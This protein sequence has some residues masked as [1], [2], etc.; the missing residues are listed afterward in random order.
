M[1]KVNI[2]I[3]IPVD[4]NIEDILVT[5]YYDAASYFI[6][7]KKIAPRT[8]KFREIIDRNYINTGE[9]YT[10]I[11]HIKPVL[12]ESPKFYFNYEYDDNVVV[13]EMIQDEC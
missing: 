1:K 11:T 4:C 5:N 10:D 9:Y 7:Y 13:W 3:E 2:E 6:T 12:W 8:L